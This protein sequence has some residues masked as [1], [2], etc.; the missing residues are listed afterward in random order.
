MRLGEII[1]N[2]F[3]IDSS[4]NFSNFTRSLYNISDK[5]DKILYDY[6]NYVYI[7]KYPPYFNKALLDI[8]CRYRY[9]LYNGL[10]KHRYLIGLING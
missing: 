9:N 2:D 6:E 1:N 4:I 5:H 10:H 7:I 8:K 3:C